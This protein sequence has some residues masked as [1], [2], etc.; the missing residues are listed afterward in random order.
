MCFAMLLITCFLF[1]PPACR[2]HLYCLQWLPT[3]HPHQLSHLRCFHK[4]PRRCRL[5]P[6]SH[7]LPTSAV[8]MTRLQPTHPPTLSLSHQGL[9]PVVPAH[10]PHFMLMLR[11]LGMQQ[12]PAGCWLHS[13]SRHPTRRLSTQWHSDRT[14]GR[15]H[16]VASPSTRGLRPPG[17]PAPLP[18]ARRLVVAWH[19][20]AAALP[21]SLGDLTGRPVLWL[22]GPATSLRRT[23]GPS[24][25]LDLCPPL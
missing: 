23:R 17:T 7:R 18:A 1:G 2:C 3:S 20:Q 22:P 11:L 10:S 15:H 9:L 19:R 24:P 16:P 12:Q 13:R 4:L 5:P 6:R 14:L 25:W 21:L 8:H